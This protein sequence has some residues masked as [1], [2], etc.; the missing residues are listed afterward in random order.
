[1]KVLIGTKNPGKIEGAKIALENYF[2]NVEIIGVSV[3][4]HVSEQPIGKE[5]YLGAKNRV[6]GLV[7]YAKKNG[8]DADF[9]M[10]V[11]SGMVFELGEW[12]V[13]NV[14]F[15][16]DKTGASS[17]GASACFPIPTKYI[18]EIKS[19][20]LGDVMDRINNQTNLHSGGGGIGILTHGVMS[21]ID[22]NAQAFTMALTKYING[23]V[24]SDAKEEKMLNR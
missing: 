3:P 5:T 9:Y 7:D 1:M 2:D 19:V 12:A 23:P 8:I 24:W 10:A 15:V 13:T 22:L 14:A 6:A 18:E 20:G 11:E 21:R 16:Q 4:S 17:F